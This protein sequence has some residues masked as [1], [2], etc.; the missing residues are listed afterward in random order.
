MTKRV[1]LA[2]I[3]GGVAL[4]FWGGLS[5]M[6]FGL[7]SVGIQNMPQPQSVMQAMQASITQPGFYF[8]PAM[9]SSGQVPADQMNGPNG[10]L[11]YHPTGT[12]KMMPGQLLTEC[13]LDI[14][15][16][17]IAAYL[18]SLVPGLGGYLAR[19][20]FVVLLGV[21]AAVMINI[22]YWNWYHF[23]TNYTLATIADKVIG[24]VVVGLVAAAIVKP[25]AARLETA[26]SRAA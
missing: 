6:V 19:V 17:L 4:F 1:L 3:L 21:L 12:M 23:P 7:G 10:I 16:A 11:I 18:L 26:S 5:H 14:V 9:D 22:Q 25:A 13:I 24:F 20:G 2:G 15:I 8:F